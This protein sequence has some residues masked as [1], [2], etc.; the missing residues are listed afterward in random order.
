MQ[1][2]EKGKQLPPPA[3][4]DESTSRES[5]WNHSRTTRTTQSFAGGSVYI[6]FS[7]R[8][9]RSGATGKSDFFSKPVGPEVVTLTQ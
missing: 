3:A 6:Y 4:I 9:L 8:K 5:L 2:P 7:I 1:S